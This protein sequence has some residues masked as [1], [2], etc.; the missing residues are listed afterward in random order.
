M[1]NEGQPR[2]VIVLDIPPPTPE[3]AKARDI[4]GRTY[5]VLKDNAKEAQDLS[6]YIHGCRLLNDFMSP[7]REELITEYGIDSVEDAIDSI[8]STEEYTDQ[9]KKRA[10]RDASL[11]EEMHGSFSSLESD[12]DHIK[13]ALRRV[14]ID[15]WRWEYVALAEFPQGKPPGRRLYLFNGI[16][17]NDHP[18]VVLFTP[19]TPCVMHAVDDLYKS[20]RKAPFQ[21]PYKSGDE[22]LTAMEVNAQGINEYQL[23]KG[24]GATSIKQDAANY[25]T[26][27]LQS[28]FFNETNAI[29]V[30]DYWINRSK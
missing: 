26:I 1:A 13:L 14:R 15:R 6:G 21:I 18:N 24:E 10:K 20:V 16:D 9:V 23:E 17:I 28:R 22:A 12:E 3:Q 5:Q 8:Y 29:P 4:I 27:G 11:T 25:L 30:S 7:Y 19:T 2:K